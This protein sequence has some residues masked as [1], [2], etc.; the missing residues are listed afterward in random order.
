MS[1]TL[2]IKGIFIK[3]SPKTEKIAGDAQTLFGHPGDKTDAIGIL[4]RVY[5]LGCMREQRVRFLANDFLRDGQKDV[6]EIGAGLG[7]LSVYLS[8][9]FTQHRYV[10]SDLTEGKFVQHFKKVKKF[11]GATGDYSLASFAAESIPFPDSS[12]DCIFIRA[13]VHHL[14]DP[15]IAFSEMHRILRLGG[16][17][18]FF[19]DPV[20]FDIP[21][22]SV[23]QKL[24]F[25]SEEKALGFNEHIYRAN[26]YLAFGRMFSARECHTDPLFLRDLEAH[27]QKW[28]SFK[29]M[30][31]GFIQ[32][33]PFLFRQFLI[34]QYGIP[35]YFVFTK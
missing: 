33:S 3:T 24:F 4:K 2:K 5:A 20:A 31:L 1:I 15:Q 18:I 27:A 30:V 10:I 35:Y 17:V 29:R 23:L 13:A 19:Q 6:L 26:E 9:I 22:I 32:M 11:F 8:T 14:E 12:F 28:S 16:K 7:D 34:R 25:G 21:I